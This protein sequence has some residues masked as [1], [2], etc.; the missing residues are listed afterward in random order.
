MIFTNLCHDLATGDWSVMRPHTAPELEY[1][2]KIYLSRPLT[3]PEAYL[4]IM[5]GESLSVVLTQGRNQI[6]WCKTVPHA[7]QLFASWDGR[8]RVAE[9]IYW[10]HETILETVGLH[11][12]SLMTRL[13]RRGKKMCHLTLAIFI[14]P[15]LRVPGIRLLITTGF[16]PGVSKASN[17]TEWEGCNN[18]SVV[19]HVLSDTSTDRSDLIWRRVDC[20]L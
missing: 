13:I 18:P 5:R 6:K 4:N 14:S 15:T 11:L 16:L 8:S 2:D 1:S 12:I 9:R 17:C 3:I 10:S 20:G 7:S 19:R